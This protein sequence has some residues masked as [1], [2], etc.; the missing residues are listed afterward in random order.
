MSE[1]CSYF[2]KFKWLIKTIPKQKQILYVSARKSFW[3]ISR[4][5][6]LTIPSG[7]PGPSLPNLEKDNWEESSW[8]EHFAHVET[9]TLVPSNLWKY[10]Y[11]R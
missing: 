2:N 1:Y 3:I 10:P 8:A 6:L 7:Y 5:N 4:C 11:Q 9:C